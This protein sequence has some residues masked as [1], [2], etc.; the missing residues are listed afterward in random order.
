M[1]KFIILGVVALVILTGCIDAKQTK[2]SPEAAKAKVVEFINTNL[3]QPGNEV[4]V[5]EITEENGLYRVVV[6]TANGQ[7]IDSYMTQDG[8]YFFP[9][10]MDI[11]K[12]EGEKQADDSA[13][14]GDQTATVADVPKAERASVELFVMSHCPYGTQ[15]EKGILP[16]LEAL[17]DKVDFELKFCDYAMHGQKEIDEQLNQYCIQKNEPEKLTTYLKCFLEDDKGDKCLGDSRI[18]IAKLNSC[19]SATDKEYKVTE[20]FE[21]KDS[22]KSGRFPQFNIYAEDTVKHAVAGSPS[23]VINGKKISSGRDSAT[24]LSTICAGYEN[25]P[26]E[27]NTELDTATPSPG[28]G[29]GTTGSANSAAS[30]E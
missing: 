25:P 8:K 26:E 16:V 3:M 30:C 18:N 17:G 27:C 24:L 20:L 5:K 1:K 21:D 13:A 10:V 9:Q 4:S 2:L 23:L 11:A 6:N 12:I 29:F 19:V 22:W 14:A 15:M 7:E 28:F